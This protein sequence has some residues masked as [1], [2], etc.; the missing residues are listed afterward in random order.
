MTETQALDIS[1]HPELQL[2]IHVLKERIALSEPHL[3]NLI[4]EEPLMEIN[5][6]QTKFSGER[7]EV[8][9]GPH[10]VTCDQKL[11]EATPKKLRSSS[12]SNF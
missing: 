8:K 12:F 4:K 9:L 6:V 2:H 10:R 3:Y 11:Y 1:Q 7:Y 5:L